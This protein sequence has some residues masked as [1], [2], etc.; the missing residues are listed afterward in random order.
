MRLI[1]SAVVAVAVPLLGQPSRP[2][3]EYQNWMKQGVEALVHQGY[4]EAVAAFQ[5]A[6]DLAPYA[7]NPRLNLATA[8]MRQ[9]D[10]DSVSIENLAIANR[11]HAEFQR[12]LDFY[13]NNE[14]AVISIGLLALGQA[15]GASGPQERGRML[16]E[17]RY[18]YRKALDINPRNR[19]AWY[20]LGLIAWKH[21]Y[22][23]HGRRGFTLPQ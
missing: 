5:R 23:N 10:P 16:D 22:P 18:W 17:A 4:E 1:L 20:N 6:V 11:S 19:E 3:S 12:V 7:L 9:Y 21:W 14:L 8:L 2:S 15:N 13:P